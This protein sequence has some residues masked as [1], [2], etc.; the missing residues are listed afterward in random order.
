MKAKTTSSRCNK[1]VSL[2]TVVITASFTFERYSVVLLA[3]HITV[4]IYGRVGHGVRLSMLRSQV[5]FLAPVKCRSVSKF[6]IPHC[7]GPPSHNGYL[8]NRS[9]IISCEIYPTLP[10]KKIT[11]EEHMP[12]IMLTNPLRRDNPSQYD[13]AVRQIVRSLCVGECM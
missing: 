12:V 13:Y 8:S 1:A 6:P 4:G 5:V 3:T 9:K 11:E 2:K 7:L 10:S